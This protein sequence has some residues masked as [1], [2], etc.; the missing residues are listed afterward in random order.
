MTTLGTSFN[1]I[2]SRTE[3]SVFHWS[4][5]STP[6]PKIMIVLQDALAILVALGVAS[7]GVLTISSWNDAS[8]EPLRIGLSISVFWIVALSLAGG[9]SARNLHS[10]VS[11]FELVLSTTLLFAGNIAILC[12]LF[13]I[14]VSRSFLLFYFALGLPGILIVRLIRRRVVARLRTRGRFQLPVLVAGGTSHVDEV[15]LA[16]KREK[17]LGYKV[18]G[19]LSADRFMETSTGIPVLG[20]V[21]DVAAIAEE[22]GAH[23]IIFAEGAF[24]ES[25]DFAQMAWQLEKQKAHLIVAP[26]LT[27]VCAE[28]ISIAPVAGLPL[29]FVSKPRAMRAGQQNKRLFDIVGSSV[30]LMLSAPIV[31]AV[32]VAIK[33]E[34][35]GRIF[36]RQTR[37]GRDREEFACY[38][39][40]SMVMNAE[41]LKQDLQS[42]NEGAGVLFKIADDPRIT[43]V[44][45][46][47][48]RFSIDELPQFWNVF[49]GDMSLV[50]PRPALPSEVA[51]Y[52]SHTV[53]R[54]DV[55]PGLTGLWQVSGRSDLPWDEAVRLDTFYVDNWSFLR[56]IA[57]ILRTMRAVLGSSGAY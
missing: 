14:D 50:G 32:A 9:Y 26:S 34:D 52:D 56:D 21:D 2:G 53:R 17:W 51:Q 15:A 20:R 12:F 31:A 18:I 45:R 27:N 16:L 39:I 19:A 38:K 29:V 57:I 23:A 33:L 55:R 28:R 24:R 35:G 8:P 36:F 48:R 11:E 43:R 5:R 7:S 13:R 47:I 30:L 3:R 6:L 25:K 49:R 46:F 10:G 4:E 1:S 44:G 42:Q 37:I 40:R 41:D 54:L 22:T